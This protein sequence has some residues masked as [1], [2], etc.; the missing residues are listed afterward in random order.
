MIFCLKGLKG[1]WK[2]I[3][4]VE[5]NTL[6]WVCKYSFLCIFFS[7]FFYILFLYILMDLHDLKGRIQNTLVLIHVLL[8]IMVKFSSY[9]L[10]K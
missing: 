5:L 4:N 9:S 6:E 7:E 3:F 2:I 1:P 10:S 8:F